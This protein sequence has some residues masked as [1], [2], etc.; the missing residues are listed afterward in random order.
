MFFAILMGV[1]YAGFDVMVKN[2]TSVE[3]ELYKDYRPYVA[4]EITIG[5]SGFILEDPN[6]VVALNKNKLTAG[7]IYGTGDW[8]KLN[9]HWCIQHRRDTGWA[10]QHGPELRIDVEF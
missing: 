10:F 1:T 7:I 9:P 4:N 2:K 3:I 8:I 6:G 5:R